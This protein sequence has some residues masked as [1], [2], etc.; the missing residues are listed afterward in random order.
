MNRKGNGRFFGRRR[1]DKSKGPQR[2]RIPFYRRNFDIAARPIL[3]IFGLIRQIAFHLWLVLTLVVCKSRNLSREGT[4]RRIRADVTAD[5]ESAMTSPAR[6][7]SPSPAEPILTQQKHYHRKAFEY[8]SKA[9]KIDEEDAG[10]M[11][12]ISSFYNHTH[13]TTA[14]CMMLYVLPQNFENK[15][16]NV[17]ACIYLHLPL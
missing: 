11:N 17:F 15:L 1:G 16:I 8:I 7:K 5:A 12:S 2:Q 14:V 6:A 4:Y 13:F 9:L 10:L 3:F